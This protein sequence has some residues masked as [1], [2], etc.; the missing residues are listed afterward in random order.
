MKYL[1]ILLSWFYIAILTS[2]YWAAARWGYD[3]TLDNEDLELVSLWFIPGVLTILFV[4]FCV[5]FV[6]DNWD[7]E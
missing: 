5:V 3:H 6:I 2:S 4:G 1:K 7:K